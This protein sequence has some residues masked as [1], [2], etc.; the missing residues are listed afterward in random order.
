MS[1][2]PLYRLLCVAALLSCG[3][4][5]LSCGSRQ[6][7]TLLSEYRLKTPRRALGRPLWMASFVASELA[8]SL[9]GD[10]TRL[11][12]A[13]D[14]KGDLD[15]WI[16]DLATGLSRR[17]TK[18]P[19]IDT[20][21]A[22]GRDR[23]TVIFVSMRQDAKGDLY[24]WRDGKIDR[25]TDSTL[26]ESY[27]TVAGDGDI[28]Y[29][30]G[31]V[32]RTRILR[33][34]PGDKQ[35]TPV[36]RWGA[37]H[38][39]LSADGKL[40]AFTWFDPSRRGR[41]VVKRLADGKTFIVTTPDYHAGFPTFSPDGRFL[42]F[43]RFYRGAS[44]EPRR[45]TDMG[46]LW[47]VPLDR[48]LAGDD[49]IQLMG[50]A[51]QL[52]SDRADVLVPRWHRRGI[53]F[54]GRHGGSLD[55]GLL[56]P[57]GLVPRRESGTAQLALAKAQRDPWDRLLCLRRVEEHGDLRATAEAQHIAAKLLEDNAQFGKAGVLL[58]ALQR[59][60]QAPYA[61]L[62][63]IEQ[64]TLPVARERWRLAKGLDNRWRAAARA[65]RAQL[66]AL[67]LRAAPPVVAA[68][69]LLRLGD[70]QRLLGRTAKAI[71]SYEGVLAR[72][73]ERREEGAKAS[74]RLGHL[75]SRVRSKGAL[76]RYYAGIFSRFPEQRA[77]LHQTAKAVIEL[78]R[79]LPPEAQIR[80]LRALSDEHPDKP[81]FRAKLLG[82]LARLHE[83]RGRLEAAVRALVREV[84]LERK[85]GALGEAAF[86][87]GALSLRYAAVLRKKGRVG[88]A[89]TFYGKALAGYQSLIEHHDPGSEVHDRARRQ[90]LRLA[91]REAAQLARGGDRGAAEK[92]YRLIVAF[93][94]SV[95]TAHRE[96]A[97]L[98]LA[99]KVPLAKIRKPY[100]D[101]VAKDASDFVGRYMLG[102]LATWRRAKPTKGDLDD[103]A[104]ELRAAL[105][106]R[107]QN[108]FVQMTLGWIFE[109]RERY[110][111]QE[112][113]GWLEEA[114]LRYDRARALIDRRLD[115]QTESD[116]LVNLANAFVALGSEW[117]RV[118]EL[119]REHRELG[120]PLRSPT[121]E[122]FHLLTC[123][124][125]A[126][127]KRRY[128]AASR[129][130]ERALELAR[131]LER[132]RLVS[133]IL[134]RLALVEHL[135][136][137]YAASNKLFGQA[138]KRLK[139]QGQRKVLAALARTRAYNAILA[140]EP[141]QALSLLDGAT[142]LLREHGTPALPSIK[143][144]APPGVD[145]SSSPLGFDRGGE[146]GVQLALRE[147]VRDNQGDLRKAVALARQ[148]LDLWSKR[149]KE[150]T[151]IEKRDVLLLRN[152]VALDALSLG[153]R[154]SFEQQLSRALEALKR[155]RSEKGWTDS[156]PALLLELALA[157]N[158]VE[159]ALGAGLSQKPAT[160]S[161]GKTKQVN[162]KSSPLVEHVRRLRAL[163]ARRQAL[164]TAAKGVPQLPARLRVALWVDLALALTRLTREPSDSR[165]T[166]VGG[167]TAAAA[168][169]RGPKKQ[170]V[171][172]LRG[173]IARAAPLLHAQRLL[174]RAARATQDAESLEEAPVTQKPHRGPLAPLWRP[175]GA[176]ERLRWHVRATLAHAALA[177]RFADRARL[178]T[179]VTTRALSKLH[180]RLRLVDVGALRYV[181]LAELAFRRRDLTAM[182]AA[183][184]AYRQ[185]WALLLGRP[186]LLSASALRRAIFD[187]AVALAVEL[188]K[189]EQAL[190]FAEQAERRAVADALAGSRLAAPA[191]GGEQLKAL[192]AAAAAHRVILAGQDVAAPKARYAAWQR[193]QIR[194]ERRVREAMVHLREAAPALAELLVVGAFPLA[195]LRR[196]LGKGEVCVGAISAGQRVWLYALRSKGPLR[197]EAVPNSLA[198]LRQRAGAARAALERDLGRLV[199]PLVGDSRRVRLDLGRVAPGL[200]PRLPTNVAV[201]RNA[202]LWAA[203]DADHVRLPTLPGALLAAGPQIPQVQGMRGTGGAA[204]GRDAL[205]QA[206]HR[207]GVLVL[208]S[209]L[210]FAG[211]TAASAE[212]PLPLKAGPKATRRW[213][214][215]KSLGLPLRYGV[216]VLPLVRHTKGRQRLERLLVL[217]L[218]HA[219]GAGRVLFS[220][221]GAKGSVAERL[222][223]LPAA[224]V[225]KGELRAAREAGFELYGDPGLRPAER[226]RRWPGLL[227]KATFAGAGAFNRRQLPRAIRLLERAVRLMTLSNSKQY[228]AGALLYLTNATAL[229]GQPGRAL[230]P[231]KRLLALRE[232]ALQKAPKS[233]RALAGVAKA[234]EQLAWLQLRS[235]R[236][237]DGLEANARAIKIFEDVKRKLLARRLYDQR[238][239][240]AERKGDHQLALRFARVTAEVASRAVARRKR[241]LGARLTAS[242]AYRRVARLLRVRFSRY[243]EAMVAAQAAQRLLPPFE[244]K[245]FDGL[246]AAK[247][248]N[249]PKVN[250]PKVNKPKVNKARAGERRAPKKRHPKRRRKP[251]LAAR[252]RAQQKL[253]SAH[254]NA[255]LSVARIQAARGAYGAAVEQAERALALARGAKLEP[256][257]ALLEVVNNLYYLGNYRRA[258]KLADQGLALSGR[259]PT[260]Q[261][262][263]LNVKGVTLSRTGRATAA[264]KVLRRALALARRLQRGGEIAATHNNIG[265]ALRT[266]G[267]FA[268]A[269]LAFRAALRIDQG[270]GDK[271]GI[272][273]DLANLGLT[274]A[275]LSLPAR[276]RRQLKEA[277]KLAG[278]IGAPIN[279]LK[280]LAGLARLDLGGGQ[281]QVARAH[282]AEGLALAR[283]LG[284]RGWIW[285]FSLLAGQA[286]RADKKLK[287]AQ[288]HFERGVAIIETSPPQQLPASG[289]PPI[290]GRQQDLYDEL[291]ELLARRG[292][293][294]ASFLLAER[295]RLRRLVDRVSRNA[296]VLPSAA[297]A[298]LRGLVSLAADASALRAARGRARDDKERA[299]IDVQLAKLAKERDALERTLTAI[300]PRLSSLVLVKTPSLETLRKALPNKTAL[301]ALHPGPR[302][303]ISWVLDRRGLSVHV[304]SLPRQRLERLVRDFRQQLTRFQPIKRTAKRLHEVLVVGSEERL[305]RARR[306]IVVP[307]GVLQLIPFAA[308]YDG[309]EH[310]LERYTISYGQSASMLLDR[311]RAVA[312]KGR[313][314]KPKRGGWASFGPSQGAEA[315][316]GIK[317]AT[318]PF[319]RREVSA[320]ARIRPGA[321][322]YGG[323]QASVAAL[324]DELSRARLLHVAL[325]AEPATNEPLQSAFVL[326]DGK[327]SLG[328]ILAASPITPELVIASSC[329]AGEGPLDGADLVGLQGRLLQLA[330][331]RR[332]IGSFWR[333]SDLGAALVVKRTLRGLAKGWSAHRALREAQRALR[334]RRPHPGFWAGFR[335]DGK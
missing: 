86:R 141:R 130:L 155:Q 252:I 154:V 277:R 33:L 279:Q 172:A 187:R 129:G 258:L 6:K 180:D 189:P 132:E 74:L 71:A 257:V 224:I 176:T 215:A 244:Q 238:S 61:Q 15:I 294:R 260:R 288:E 91:L 113:R 135:R 242:S 150:G 128:R 300:N 55:V 117:D 114:L 236:Y 256:R 286:E 253:A 158:S 76:A 32:S 58:A 26:G 243:R 275:L 200:T 334:R 24:R 330:G 166:V 85:L 39:A 335:L 121:Q 70:M 137:N 152:Q 267:R 247:A 311:G 218:F 45:P 306:V 168:G 214:L 281:L 44:N 66:T 287:R 68:L 7:R 174:S 328:E 104:K 8:G 211:R 310:L 284:L 255:L 125:A 266:R 228:L 195:Q 31:G 178:A 316:P 69:R 87:L 319:A 28:Y 223:G 134:L 13:S 106:L 227:K 161:P 99:R 295:S 94:R 221:P 9:D 140:G 115:P 148:R 210:H 145:P 18:D 48:V 23:K 183:V 64:I 278:S 90:Y 268:E 10:G 234:L 38:P 80:A 146:R 77:V 181:V 84:Q 274:N 290:E 100:A 139:A 276:S 179:H 97:R 271:L 116:L 107:P 4:L 29:A 169:A 333:V 197:L 203:L 216:V 35:G 73:P 291:I 171:A 185:R 199:A 79:A 67:K 88:E 249:K 303:V 204:L 248:A 124:R 63:H 96:L 305:D 123:A 201:S 296:S 95:L 269:K 332:V 102:L 205:E 109:M 308:L 259:F 327:L 60:K 126:T 147:I 51:R 149:A 245:R 282:A 301:L 231:M 206:M 241:S 47:R 322:T 299:A 22:W 313:G 194:A 202:T 170:V 198:T 217:R 329:N 323:K 192:L 240:I 321:R 285:R 208:G 72:Y 138:A 30:A 83:Q 177:T 1:R 261:I 184:R 283:K 52:T 131:R 246:I 136:G 101:A 108:P 41:V 307:A 270:R 143:Q 93:D 235:K 59:A 153:D 21:P 103:A 46:S 81:L 226:K 37:T 250:K 314:A 82:R 127:A 163:E 232:A 50:K 191:V 320:L 27:P 5:L 133:E 233:L 265:D 326:A 14:E 17:L 251:T 120:Y 34:T 160:A 289:T 298:P 212:L 186:Y 167:W 273:F 302:G 225:A 292:D 209:E 318:L 237:A 254:Q 62:A 173:V 112:G 98:A 3:G 229:S 193:S 20:Q 331:A 188:G 280:A 190:A 2:R 213:Q 312:S 57:D 122:A 36:S 144:V 75:F 92:R 12:Y 196:M 317:R 16:K 309:K 159:A 263:F 219:M 325:H 119:C 207:T 264:L 157:L 272:S 89:I 324:R 40:L 105:S 175:L 164:V 162:S 262:Q 54:S 11:L 110:L 56:S 111:G 43:V 65:A 165:K 118:E 222:R 230:A 304:V 293:A 239:L 19:A 53:V 151:A 220:S 315:S 25:L 78:Y 42:A 156:V 297:R 182:T 49:A 142:T